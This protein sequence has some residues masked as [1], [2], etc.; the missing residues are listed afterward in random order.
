M[1][2]IRKK[3][4]SIP[5]ILWMYL[6]IY[7][8][9]LFAPVLRVNCVWFVMLPSAAYILLN[10]KTMKETVSFRA[11]V[12]TEIILGVLLVYL[13][14]MAKINGNSM[15]QFAYYVYWIAGDVPF[16]LA[17]WIY[18][19]KNG[20]GFSELLDHLLFTGLT[21][22]ALA[23]GAFLVPPLKEFFIEK[24][25]AY[26]IPYTIKL[27]AYRHFGFAANLSS[28]ASY[29]QVLLAGIAM[30]RGIRG[31]P[32]WLIAFPVLA[33]SANINTRTAIYLMLAGMAA[34]FAGVLFS[35]DL[36]KTGKFFAVAV[37][38]VVIAYFGLGLIRYVNPMTR[39]WLAEGIEQV[40]SFTAGEEA[41]FD[42]SY[43]GELAWML[44]PDKFPRGLRLVFGAGTEV[45]GT[46]VEAKYGVSS[47]V[48]FV[49]DIWRGGIVYLAAILGLFLYTLRQMMRSRT[50]RREDGMFLALL[51]LAFFG[52][53]NIKGHFFIHSD[54]AVIFFLLTAALVWNRETEQQTHTSSE[55]VLPEGA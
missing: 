39:D 20:L 12:L 22:A 4:I 5:L 54:V 40:S 24:M 3:K 7:N 45:M 51:F 13:L 37:P 31:K 16:A 26:G 43:F 2:T 29:A 19:R 25:V 1:I 30:Y 36:K 14:A 32:L 44:A 18:L 34:V 50:L 52:L 15:T 49:S 11:V 55:N 23:V 48:G 53:T 41:T 10:W 6:L 46:V 21:M 27:S 9:P 42:E 8:P 17:C 35:R 47:D 38:A 33:F 28:T